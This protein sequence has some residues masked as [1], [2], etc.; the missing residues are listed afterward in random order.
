MTLDE[1]ASASDELQ[2]ALY[3]GVLEVRFGD[4]WI[5]YQSTADIQKALFDL[6]SQIATTAAP[7]TVR[8]M[9]NFTIFNG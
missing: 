3:S 8:S 2:K 9:C 7:N 5:K 1:L 6:K 4:R